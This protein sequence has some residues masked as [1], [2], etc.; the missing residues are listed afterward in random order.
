MACWLGDAAVA[1]A[2]RVF[3]DAGVADYATPEE[4]VRAF[5]HAR[6]LPPQPGAAA[7]GAD[8]ERRTAAP[9]VAA[10]RAMHRGALA[11]GR[12]MLDE[13]E[14]KAVLKAYG[15]PVVRDRGGWSHGR[16][17]SGAQRASSATRWR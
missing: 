16:C 8:R 7:G 13:L 6:D 12:D 14:A 1:E 4:A 2:R 10:A 17:G 5:A 3:E 9:D 11:D 15:I